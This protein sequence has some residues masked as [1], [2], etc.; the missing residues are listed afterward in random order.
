[1]KLYDLKNNL[2]KEVENEIAVDPLNR[3]NPS[4]LLDAFH[5]QNFFDAIRRGVPLK[6][7][8]VGGHQSTLLMQ[9]GN[10]A[11][12]TGRTLKV[13]PSN[14]HILQDPDRKSTRLNS[15]HVKIS[16]AVFCLKKKTTRD[17]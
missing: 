17:R 3:S 12:R 9:L 2:I 15:S 13:D 11:Q 5:I 4:Q 8:I 1:Y 7:D 6:S 16:Y 10:I 14:G